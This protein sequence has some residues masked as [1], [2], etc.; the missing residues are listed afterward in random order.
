MNKRKLT[1]QDIILI[2]KQLE[3]AEQFNELLIESLTEIGEAVG[4]VEP[5]SINDQQ[6]AE[7]IAK[8]K[9]ALSKLEKEVEEFNKRMR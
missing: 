9:S 6:A 5:A 7:V 8:V 2:Q 4:G 3:I 1:A